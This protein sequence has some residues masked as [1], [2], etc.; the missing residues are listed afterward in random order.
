MPLN[1]I[2]AAVET[3]IRATTYGLTEELLELFHSNFVTAGSLE[4]QPGWFDRDA[5]IGFCKENARPEDEPLPAWRIR[6][7]AAFETSAFAVVESSFLNSTFVE[8]LTFLWE[9]GRWQ[10]AF[11]SFETKD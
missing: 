8:V 4:G 9:E 11:K 10:L 7:A 2:E 1:D 5:A 6:D 3:Y